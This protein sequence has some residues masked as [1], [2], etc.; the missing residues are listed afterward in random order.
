AKIHGVAVLGTRAHLETRI[1]EYG[2]QEVIIAIPSASATAMREIFEVCGRTGARFKTVPTRGELERGAARLSQI[3]LVE[4]EDLLGRE[5]IN[6]NQQVL[7]DT[8]Q[9]RR[10]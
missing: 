2:I 10:V 7:R 3:H 1:R 4:L 5:L 8:H 9:G 6:L